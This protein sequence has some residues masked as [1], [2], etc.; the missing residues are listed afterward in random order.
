MKLNID[1]DE[2]T[3]L[4]DDRV[5]NMRKMCDKY[6]DEAYNPKRVSSDKV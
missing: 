4:M 3:K 6:E 1:M 2:H 5:N